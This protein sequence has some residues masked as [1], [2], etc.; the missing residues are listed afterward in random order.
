MR[1]KICELEYN[2]RTWKMDF[3]EGVSDHVTGQLFWPPCKKACTP[4]VCVYAPDFSRASPGYRASESGTR[5]QIHGVIGIPSVW[6]SLFSLQ[7][8]HLEKSSL[9][10]GMFGLGKVTPS[11]GD[12]EILIER[13]VISE[14]V[15]TGMMYE[16]SQRLRGTSPFY[17][18]LTSC[19]PYSIL[20]GLHVTRSKK[21]ATTGPPRDTG[22]KFNYYYSHPRSH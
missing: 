1:H 22:G 14:W 16:R 21:R 13:R 5:I 4:G 18:L 20:Y 12:L 19:S 8:I 10:R 17:S 2:V 11:S 6:A 15:V 3:L 9:T 7:Q